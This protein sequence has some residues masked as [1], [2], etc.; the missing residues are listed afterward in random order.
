MGVVPFALTG[1]TIITLWRHLVG[2]LTNCLKHNMGLMFHRN[3]HYF[4]TLL[5]MTLL[6][7]AG[8]G[9]SFSVLYTTLYVTGLIDPLSDPYLL[10]GGYLLAAW[11]SF[12]VA[13]NIAGLTQM[14][15]SVDRF[16][17]PVMYTCRSQGHS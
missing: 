12:G 3:V 13:L 14:N 6:E 8:I 5:S 4:D 2:Q 1:Y 10:V 9:L 11:F 15:G 7:V 17:Q 16:V